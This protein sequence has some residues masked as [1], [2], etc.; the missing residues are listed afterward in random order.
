MQ[1]ASSGDNLHEMSKP[2]FWKKNKKNNSKCHLLNFLPRVLSVSNACCQLIL[3][4]L[5]NITAKD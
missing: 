1:T 3:L 5:Q 4:C 2:V